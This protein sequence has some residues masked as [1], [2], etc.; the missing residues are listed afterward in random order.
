MA[1]QHLKPTQAQNLR[2]ASVKSITSLLMEGLELLSLAP[3]CILYQ[4]ASRW[5]RPRQEGC[6][7]QA[8]TT[9]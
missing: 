2:V 9:I 3:Q 5:F 6:R 7:A 8:L 1:V 4:E